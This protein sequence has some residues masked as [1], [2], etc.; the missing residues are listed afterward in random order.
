M[1]LAGQETLVPGGRQHRARD[2]V[3]PLVEQGDAKRG[4]GYLKTASSKAPGDANIR[5]HLA[6]ALAKSGDKAGARKELEQVMATKG[7]AKMDEARALQ[8][9]L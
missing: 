4:L 6:Q 8:Q 5:L 3:E 2:V 7:F 9:S 1:G